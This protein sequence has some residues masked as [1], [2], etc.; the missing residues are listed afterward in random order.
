MNSKT[1]GLAMF[2]LFLVTGFAVQTL[3]QEKIA[4]EITLVPPSG[5]GPDSSGNIEGRVTGAHPPEQY[6]VVLYAHTDRWY[7]Q[8]LESPPFT[9]V[10]PSGK[11]SNWTHLGNRYAA[12]LVR[13]S[14]RVES[15]IQSLPGLGG[16]VI[17]K[18]EVAAPVEK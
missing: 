18:K 13:P 2:G 1:I 4:I 17:A 11:W 16:D 3:S 9:D 5:A 10:D 6:K 8:P 7:V 15:K 12:L 14:F